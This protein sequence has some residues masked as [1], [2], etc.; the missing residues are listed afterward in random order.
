M[1]K[2]ILLGALCG[3]AIAAWAQ[4]IPLKNVPVNKAYYRD[5]VLYVVATNGTTI[6]IGATTNISAYVTLSAG[7]ATI[8]TNDVTVYKVEGVAGNSGTF[9]Y[10]KIDGSTG[11]VYIASG[12]ITN[13]N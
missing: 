10:T 3:V 1:K 13:K 4:G 12:I 2:M 5:G 8:T 7:T 9:Q 11:T 6:A